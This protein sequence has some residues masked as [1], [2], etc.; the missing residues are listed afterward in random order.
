MLGE[1]RHLLEHAVR[2]ATAGTA[3]DDAALWIL[4]VGREPDL[5]EARAVHRT[6]MPRDVHRDHRDVLRHLV[7]I[8]ARRMPT[9]QRVVVTDPEDPA[10]ST[11]I[12]SLR[13]FLQPDDEFVDGVHGTVGRG[14]QV[15]TD[16]LRAEAEHVRVS[17]DEARRKR[18]ARQ[19]DVLGC[20]ALVGL[21]DVCPLADGEDATVLHGD[22]FGDG[23]CII[24]GDD[25]ATCVDDIG[26]LARICGGRLGWYVRLLS[27]TGAADGGGNGQSDR[28]TFP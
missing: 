5:G 23:L 22:R 7:E 20:R 2:F 15:G 10:G 28:N 17:V 13:E 1:A 18:V 27:T 24:H 6:E 3:A 16:G 8:V 9:Q 12:R 14:E 25:V 21:L 11:D 26:R 4:A 19:V